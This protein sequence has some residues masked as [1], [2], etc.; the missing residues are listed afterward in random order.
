MPTKW[1]LITLCVCKNSS[2]KGAAG[3]RERGSSHS[4]HQHQQ[5][6]TNHNSSALSYSFVESGTA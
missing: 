4:C 1:F 6:G 2:H 3:Q 5:P